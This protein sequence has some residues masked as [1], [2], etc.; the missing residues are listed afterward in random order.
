[1][2]FR[3][4]FSIGRWQY[5]HSFP[6]R[7]SLSAHLKHANWC[8]VSPWTHS[9]SFG[10]ELQI[11]H[12]PGVLR[13]FFVG[14]GSSQKPSSSPLDEKSGKTLTI[15]LSDEMSCAVLQWGRSS[16]AKVDWI[17]P[18]PTL[19]KTV[20][21]SKPSSTSWDDLFLPASSWHLCGGRYRVQGRHCRG[22]KHLKHWPCNA[23]VNVEQLVHCHRSYKD[24]QDIYT[25]MWVGVVSLMSQWLLF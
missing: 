18:P 7:F 13:L 3:I 2:K 8:E 24:K 25:I 17:P 5:G 23:V 6:F 19:G 11:K 9:A 22:L 20:P 14:T 16:P 15:V 1:M 4:T 21:L 10:C 12:I